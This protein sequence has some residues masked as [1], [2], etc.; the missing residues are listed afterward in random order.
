MKSIPVPSLQPF[1]SLGKPEAACLGVGPRLRE[2]MGEV[3]RIQGASFCPSHPNGIP[4][5]SGGVPMA[6]LLGL[7]ACTASLVSV[8]IGRSHCW[9]CHCPSSPHLAFQGVNVSLLPLEYKNTSEQGHPPSQH[10]DIDT[11]PPKL[12]TRFATG[13]RLPQQDR[14][15]WQGD[16]IIISTH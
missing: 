3:E 6:T 14:L 15:P 11:H 10:Q 12:P 13:P 4:F 9:P 2:G 5:Q 7:S 8:K 16:P 1:R